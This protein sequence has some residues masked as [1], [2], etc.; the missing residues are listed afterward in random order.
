MRKILVSLILLVAGFDLYSQ[1]FSNKGKE[2]YLCF[3]T[4]VPNNAANVATLSIYITSDKASSGTI[5]M[6]NGAFTSTFN[7]APNGLQEIQIPWA[8][9]RHISN[10]EANT[11]IRKSILI[12]TNPGMP[13]VVAYAQQWAGARSAAT[14]LLPVNVLGK[15]YYASSFTQTPGG[16]NAGVQSRSQFQIIAIKNNTVVEIT[17]RKNG[18]VQ[19]TITVNLPL[20]GDMYEYQS[21]DGNASSQDITGTYIE[22]VASGVGG[23]LP[24]AVF[25]GSSN[26]TFGSTGCS[27][28]NSYDPLWQQV[29]P[30]STWG[31]NFGFIPFQG[32]SNGNPYRVMASE[33]NTNVFINGTQVATLNAGEIYPAA[34]SNTPV[35]LNQVASITSDKPVCVTQYEQRNSC[36]GAGN[37]Q[38]D[39][40]MV[41]LNPIEQNIS[42]ISIFSSTNQAI[43]Q[44]YVNV[45]TK[46]NSTASFMV[47]GAPIIPARGTW[48]V[49]TNLPGYSYLKYSLTGYTA[50][51][52]T[53]DSGFNAIAYGMGANES[54]AYS[55]GTFIRDLTQQLAVNSQYGIETGAS[56]CT[57]APFEFK[58]CFPAYN[59]NGTP[60]VIDSMDWN[61]S[62]TAVMVP[63][64]FPRRV[65]NPVIDSV[66]IINGKEVNWYHLDGLYNFNTVGIYTITITNFSSGSD[67]CGSQ[68]DFEFELEVS[69]PPL[70]DFNWTHNGCV[71]Q[72]VQFNDQTTTVKPTYSWWWDFGDPA[73]GGVNN[74]SAL[75]N[76]THSFSGPGTYNVRYSTIT[77]PGCLSDT[78]VK[79]IVINP[80]PGAAISGDIIVCQNEASPNLVF[81]GSVGTAPYTFTYNINNGPAQTITTTTG[82]S[83]SLPVPTATTG[84]YSYHLVSVRDAAG[85]AG[86]FQAT[87]DTVRVIV[88]PLPAAT[89]T[90]AT[91]VCQN[92]TEP[93]ITFTAAGGSVQPFTFSYTINNGP[94]QTISTISGNSVTLNVPT[95]TPGNFV[96]DLVSVRDASATACSQTQTGSVTVIVNPLPAATLAGT[97]EVCLNAASPLVTFTGS[98]GIA[99]YTF[100]YT[101]NGG[102][103]QTITSTGNT[104]TVT[105]PATTAGTFVYT[106]VSVRDA[107]AQNCSQ[108]QTGTATVVVHPLPTAGFNFSTPSCITRTINFTDNSTP[109]AGALNGWSWNFGDPSSGAANTS[110]LQNPTHVFATAGTYTVTLTVTN[111][112]G[113][114]NAVPFQQT[115]T[116][117]T[118]P[119]AAFT[120][121]EVCLLDPFAQF[122]DLSTAVNPAT[123][124]GWQWNFGDPASG[125][126][127]TSTV[128]NA[129]H[130]FSAVGNYTVRLVVT[131]NNGCTDTLHQVLTVN[132]GNPVSG[133]IQLNPTTS[134]SS[135]TVSIQNKSTIAS[136]SIT[137]VDIYWDNTNNPT[138][139]E[140]DDVPVFDKIYR[141]KYPTS[142]STVNY[143]VRFR[144]YSGGVCVN[145]R[146]L[147]VTVLATPDVAIATISDQ[148]YT[149]TP[150]ILNFGTETGGV[151][152]ATTY[153]GPGVSFDGTNW[154]FN[155]IT[156]GIGT[157]NIQYKFTATAGGCAD[158]ISTNIIVLDTAFARFT[159][160]SP[161]CEKSTVNFTEQSSAPSTVTLANTIWDFG[162][163][164]LP[165][166]HAVGGTVTHTYA[167]AGTYTVTMYNIAASGC[168]SASVVQ[169]VVIH[170]IPAPNF[171]IPAS[172]CLPAASAS[173]TNTSSIADGTENTFTYLWNF[174][175]PASGAANGSAVK[176]GIHIY[177]GAGPFNVNLQVTSG[178]GCV[179]DTTI[180][181]NTLHPQPKA[182]FTISKSAICIGDNVGFTSQ[183][184]GADGTIVSWNWNFDDG[185]APSA[186]PGPTHLYTT[187]GNYNVQH[188]ITNSFGC[189]S[190]TV[191][192]PF[193]VYAIPTVDAG[194]DIFVLESGTATLDPTYT[195]DDN[196]YLWTPSDYLNSTTIARPITKPLMDIT[197]TITVSNPGGCSNSD[198]VFVKVL[199]GPKIPNTFSPNGD[200]INDKWI[201]EFLDTYP[202]C[203][204]LVF[205]RAGQKVFESRGYK[206]PWNGTIN[207]KSLPLDTYYYIIEPENG[208]KAVTGYVTIIK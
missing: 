96:Y 79:Q 58:V 126:N 6:A 148:C 154:I 5:T 146:I 49:A 136:G 201:I 54:Y 161:A 46:T 40:D 188:F 205:T 34:F 101:L 151:V 141:H 61:S 194:P 105:V 9:N 115:V 24:I 114:S 135:D 150:L 98:A 118:L 95:T 82:N 162:D 182:E 183:S 66:R 99:P 157:H 32:F 130:A 116:I 187:A 50:A 86:C 11:V 60:Y 129:Q 97:T 59:A 132:G 137:K 68:Q 160:Q 147:P 173:F 15:K 10:A 199:L 139:Y 103:A 14:L 20:A 207:G 170:P 107:S 33:N 181:L 55:A 184:G 100:T 121:P 102:P 48:Q 109:N 111:D 175:D 123:I 28:G 94:V 108:A 7:I 57:G 112:K 62:N 190:D 144:A 203:K 44:Q 12:K 71:D 17:P 38:G 122:T 176:D 8:A 169:Q 202:N 65:I 39:P 204:V 90:G 1:D 47:N 172:I 56:I 64:D 72:V 164:S 19:P 140:T 92:A 156:A 179:H 193:K 124:T 167:A 83:V 127:N 88:N 84:T 27:T 208:R 69:N 155:S 30:V 158:S 81:T 142:S 186:D 153:S 93:V 42:D 138:I 36:S 163:G 192:K 91:T 196:I 73:S 180:I 29:Y 18:V 134:C 133:F 131:T 22:S 189:N 113:C 23:C 120:L 77:T 67:A 174:G 206:V 185:S 70:A 159:L 25:S 198:Q 78:I 75:Q 89:L 200:G 195:G 152:G 4:H 178:A 166:T 35:L 165:E 143:N 45:L 43:T 76:P 168:R 2:F 41:V 149:S 197:Y 110:T 16:D 119:T 26:V 85:T 106:L 74:T 87:P 31:K 21:T 37:T 13:A 128:Q 177:T 52:L 145:D 125:A 191:S 104:A 3:P 80:L 51:R 53:G 171:T 117:S 63:N